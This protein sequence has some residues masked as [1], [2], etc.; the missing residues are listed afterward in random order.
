MLKSIT[1]FN[2]KL[3]EKSF[4]SFNYLH[5]NK[6]FILNLISTTTISTNKMS[7]NGYNTT[8][9]INNNIVSKELI[10]KGKKASAYQAIDENIDKVI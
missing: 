6:N 7:T 10:E 8:N 3:F 9:A 4:N 1:S 5:S 2:N